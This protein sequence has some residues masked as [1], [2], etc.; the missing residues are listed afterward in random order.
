MINRFILLTTS[1]TAKIV[2]NILFLSVLF[3]FISLFNIQHANAQSLGQSIEQIRRQSNE[4]EFK[5][6]KKLRDVQTILNTPQGRALLNNQKAQI[7][8][9]FINLLSNEILYEQFL[10]NPN[11]PQ[12]Q[13]QLLML[14]KSNPQALNRFLDQQ[15]DPR[16]LAKQQKSEIRTQAEVER[17]RLKIRTLR[18]SLE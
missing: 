17:I 15:S 7:R 10:A 3:N 9:Q 18:N 11:I 8:N 1:R 6:D 16:Y 5:V 14:F 4:A 13:K 2:G 12:S